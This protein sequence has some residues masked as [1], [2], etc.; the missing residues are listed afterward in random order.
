MVLLLEIS[1]HLL[2]FV[3]ASGCKKLQNNLL[4]AGDIVPYAQ[5]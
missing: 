3:I 2:D 1:F 4:R 5:R